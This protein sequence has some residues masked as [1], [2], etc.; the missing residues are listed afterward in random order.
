MKKL[1]GN[2]YWIFSRIKALSDKKY[3]RTVIAGALVLWLI[4]ISTT[5]HTAQQRFP[6]PEFESGYVQPEPTKPEPRSL[7]IEY[8]DVFVLILALS[9]V[10]YMSIKSRSR[11]GIL[12]VSIFSLLYFGFWRNGCVCAIGAVQNVSLAI[13]DG[14][15]HI[16][17][18]VIAFFIIP[19][20][21]AL[22]AGRAF[23][24]GVCPLGAIQ[25]IVVLK[26]LRIPV[27]WQKILGFIPYVYLSFAILYAVT[28][29]DFIICRYDPFI[30]IFRMDAPVNMI[31]LGGSFL[32][33]GVF[34]A[35]PY[36]RFF[37]PY[38]IL[39]NWFS[40]FSKHRVTVTPSTCIQ[41]RL[42][43]NACPFDVIHYPKSGKPE[44]TMKQN[45][46][47]IILFT[48][49]IPVWMFIGGWAL[50]QLHVPVSK[51]NR[52][53]SL[54]EEVLRNKKYD[55]QLKS[56]DVETFEESGKPLPQLLEEAKLIID[57][58]YTGT[59]IVGAFLG[60]IIG[61]GV[62]RE[63][64]YKSS[65]DYEPDKGACLSCGRCF[66]YCPVKKDSKV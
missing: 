8:L 50:S 40:W 19:L 65:K 31:I 5:I 26:P 42:C 33:L 47:R 38:A 66:K 43:E 13:A 46:R 64:V 41:C 57:D 61:M 53:V 21:F 52:T 23:C 10:T 14:S 24:G 58:F 44:G 6:K 59:W 27:F 32:L 62:L 12:I 35:R 3:A 28:G 15:Y 51:V 9:L 30:G 48:L 37:C 16:P 54:A 45:K 18:V 4:I 49:L 25:D 34:I 63:S 7:E 2:I 11:R 29:S 20:L 39:L 55:V 1:V 22:F 36:C 17:L 56:L 60:L